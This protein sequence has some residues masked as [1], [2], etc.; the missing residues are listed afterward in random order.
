V[1]AKDKN[2]LLCLFVAGWWAAMA[3]APF[4]LSGF[5]A[6][7]AIASLFLLPF[8]AMSLRWRSIRLALY[9]VAAWNVYA[10]SFLPGLLRPRV[11]PTR[12]IDSITLK[13]GSP[14]DQGSTFA[15]RP[16]SPGGAQDR[17][18]TARGLVAG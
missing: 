8:A 14:V 5:A 18:P 15:E 16:R 13:S 4:L 3:S 11:S 17:L 9:S 12:W 2:T 7:L 6:V 1:V 10:A